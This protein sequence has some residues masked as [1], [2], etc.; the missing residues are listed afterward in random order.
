[1]EYDEV[2]AETDHN[3]DTD[4]EA[5]EDADAEIEGDTDTVNVFHDADA[6]GVTN[7]EICGDVECRSVLDPRGVILR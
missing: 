2:C 4:V 3:G 6:E 1:M 5:E 7:T